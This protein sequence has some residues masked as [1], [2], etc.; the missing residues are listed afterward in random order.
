MGASFVSRAP[1]LRR[2]KSG[3]RELTTIHP[4]LPSPKSKSSDRC[5]ER[6]GA[7][8]AGLGRAHGAAIANAVAR[9]LGQ[10]I[11]E[12]PLSRER[13]MSILLNS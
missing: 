2:W 11:R 9:V 10:R 13:I 3:D 5:A 4:A 1:A 12:L 7:R 6:A 8:L